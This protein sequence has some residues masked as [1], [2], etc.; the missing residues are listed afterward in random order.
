[1][2]IVDDDARNVFALTNVLEGRGMRRRYAENG[3]DAIR[4]L[5]DDADSTSS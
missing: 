5:E 4:M 3:L 1:M 2:L